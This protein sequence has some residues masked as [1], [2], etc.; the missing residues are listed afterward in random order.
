MLRR[1]HGTKT[2]YTENDSLPAQSAYSN[3]LFY[4]V[5]KEFCGSESKQDPTHMQ[6]LW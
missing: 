4:K 5:K 3:Q 1:E 2:Q 6:G